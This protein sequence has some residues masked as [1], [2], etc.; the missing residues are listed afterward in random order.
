MPFDAS[1]WRWPHLEKGKKPHWQIL[2]WPQ[3]LACFFWDVSVICVVS[4]NNQ[5]FSGRKWVSRRKK[6]QF[7][8]TPVSCYNQLWWYM[9]IL[10]A[11]SRIYLTRSAT[12]N[13]FLDSIAHTFPVSR[14]S[15]SLQDVSGQGAGGNGDTNWLLCVVEMLEW[16]VCHSCIALLCLQ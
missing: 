9:T 5:F 10:L 12:F 2:V 1:E 14:I 8:P 4:Q 7:N 16:L 13:I 11:V 15:L 3:T 6:T